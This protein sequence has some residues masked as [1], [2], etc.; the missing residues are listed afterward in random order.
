VWPLSSHLLPTLW[1]DDV[2]S[3]KCTT[4]ARTTLAAYEH[5]SFLPLQ[6]IVS[7]LAVA[8]PEGPRSDLRSA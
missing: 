6:L 7:V 1:A 2:E 3:C 4:A 8:Q 5:P